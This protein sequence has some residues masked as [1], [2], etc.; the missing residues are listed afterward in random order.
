MHCSVRC[1]LYFGFVGMAGLDEGEDV[2]LMRQN[3][4]D[5][6]NEN[7]Y[8]QGIYLVGRPAF[9]GTPEFRWKAVTFML[10]MLRRN[11]NTQRIQTVNHNNGTVG[12]LR[13]GEYNEQ[14][15]AELQDKESRLT[16]WL[17]SNGNL[18]L[19]NE[20]T[21]RLTGIEEDVR[22]NFVVD[23]NMQ[24]IHPD[25]IVSGFLNIMR[26]RRNNNDSFNRGR[27]HTLA[28]LQGTGD[29][30]VE[31]IQEFFKSQMGDPR[32]YLLDIFDRVGAGIGFVE[33]RAL[34]QSLL[35]PQL[36]AVTD[37]I[38]PSLAYNEQGYYGEI[39]DYLAAK[40]EYGIYKGKK[41]FYET[42]LETFKGF[43][44]VKITRRRSEMQEELNMVQNNMNHVPTKQAFC[45]QAIG[46]GGGLDAQFVAVFGA[47][48]DLT[49]KYLVC[50]K[51]EDRSWMEN[52]CFIGQ[53]QELRFY[54]H[55]TT[56]GLVSRDAAPI[57][58]LQVLLFDCTDLRLN[59][60]FGM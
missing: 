24:P 11:A 5:L 26:A 22:K 44:D 8:T 34:V 32:Q 2:A 54:I 17:G 50:R 45:D 35:A 31:Q 55:E 4:K 25:M 51:D 49:M 1:Q 39:R 58:A 56:G 33:N 29:G 38:P 57:K 46:A 41:W 7:H 48:G 9:G 59:E 14:R 43:S 15:L 3:V 19:S 20:L 40:L 18:G 47:S 53:Q 52:N 12:F 37:T 28:A 16:N 60:L 23:A 10:D 21:N 27:A 30:L 36:K 6:L 42:L 13:Y